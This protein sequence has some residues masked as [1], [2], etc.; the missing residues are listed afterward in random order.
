M[1]VAY[2]IQLVRASWRHSFV[3]QGMRFRFFFRLAAS[4]IVIKAAEK[5]RSEAAKLA[6]AATQAAPQA[7]PQSLESE[8][9]SS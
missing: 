4:L 3:E 8:A 1:R 9:A 6:Q 5:S 7:A 2:R